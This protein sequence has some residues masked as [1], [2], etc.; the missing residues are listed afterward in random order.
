M[1]AMGIF[2]HLE[3]RPGVPLHQLYRERLEYLERADDAGFWCFFKSEHHL[4]PLDM[5]P[6]PGVF[7]SAVA[8][9]TRQ[10]RLGPLVYLLPFYHPLRLLEEIAMLDHL[11]G[12]R[13][14]VGVGRGVA[15]PEH[16]LWGLD[17]DEARARCDETLEVLLA[18][19]AGPELTFHGRFWDFEAVPMEL[20]PLQRPH[21]PLW[22]PG[23]LH[24]A[25][26]RGFNTVVGGP[27]AV[28]ADSVRRYRE[29][30]AAAGADARVNPG[31]AAPIVAATTRICLARTDAEAVARA[32]QAWQPYTRNIT[33]LW[34][35]FGLFELPRDPTVGGD[36]DRAL[37]LSVCVAGSPA[38]LRDWIAELTETSGV[39]HLIVSMTW[40]DLDHR[41]AMRSFDLL[42]EHVVPVA[43]PT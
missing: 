24:T 18:G 43:S 19:F 17:N 1:V 30:Y 16:Q 23:T 27:P 38:R 20:T 40:G 25:A 9:R 22:Y 26:S 36:F 33:K 3:A 6:S 13:L 37:E 35:Q 21:P 29:V 11:S 4:T 34:H 39:E 5:A 28:V 12:G 15:P 32:R 42:C 7:L 14:E 2:D 10:I 31:P 8:E 41:E